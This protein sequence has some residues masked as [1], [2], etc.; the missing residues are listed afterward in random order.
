MEIPKNVKTIDWETSIMWFDEDGVLY[1][2]SKP[3]VKQPELTR[4][5]T[6]AQM[7][8][9]KELIGHKKVCMI[10]ETNSNGS[11]PKKE[12]RD[13]IADQLTE[14]TQAMGIVSTSPL[15]RMLA[16]LFFGFKPP[17]Y[18]V[19]FFSNEKDAKEWIKQYL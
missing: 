15:G 17:Q 9:F 7:D 5:Q 8:K 6:L 3:D 2:K 11:T 18:P 19:K 16:N 10:L 4:E 1:S 12:E 13:F 14:V